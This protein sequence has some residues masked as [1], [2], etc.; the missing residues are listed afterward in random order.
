[1][2]P[3]PPAD[4]DPKQLDLYKP[5]K[6]QLAPAPKHRI[7]WSKLMARTLGFDPLVCPTCKGSMRVVGFV[8]QPA[9]IQAYL[10]WRGLGS[11]LPPAY[12][13]TGPPQLELPFPERAAAA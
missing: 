12:Q 6:E 10:R 11:E 8:T 4:T 5:G 1:V 3:E 2:V 13:P 7:E 9:R